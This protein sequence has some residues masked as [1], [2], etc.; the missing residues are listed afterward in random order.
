MDGISMR[1]L[2][3]IFCS[4]FILAGCATDNEYRPE[5]RKK[6]LALAD[7]RAVNFVNS[8]QKLPAAIRKHLAGIADAGEAFS[9]DCVGHHP[10]RRFLTA[11][12]KGTTYDVAL[13]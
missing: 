5:A 10:H 8:V 3:G 6:L 9:A 2:L 13:E 7:G 1:L 11:T 12:K 4:W